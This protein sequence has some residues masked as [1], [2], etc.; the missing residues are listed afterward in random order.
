MENPLDKTYADQ[1]SANAVVAATAH[2]EAVEKA[3]MAQIVEGLP[4]N[5]LEVIQM[6][7]AKGIQVNVNGK[8]DKMQK[9]L[10]IHNAKHEQDMIRILP[11]LTAFENAQGDLNTAKRGG[12]IVLWL[13]GSVSA[14]GGA[15]LVLRAIFLNH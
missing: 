4:S 15:Y 6:E 3:R 10:D 9:G 14:I 8:I 7:I 12:K 2:A 11:V 13:A 5:L 1:A